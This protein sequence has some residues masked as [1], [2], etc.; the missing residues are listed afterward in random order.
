MNNDLTVNMTQKG[1]PTSTSL[2]DKV[3]NFIIENPKLKSEI[4][5]VVSSGQASR[6]EYI[7]KIQELFKTA[8]KIK[9]TKNFFRKAKVSNN[10]TA[11]NKKLSLLID[12]DI[13]NWEHYLINIKK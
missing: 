6:M 8:S 9:G 4:Y 5:N 3:V 7:L 12:Q 11:S 10:E 13:P 2:I 1:V